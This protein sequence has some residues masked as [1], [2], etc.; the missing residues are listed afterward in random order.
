MN[1]RNW[2][3]RVGAIAE[4]CAVGSK[5][6]ARRLKK[7]I[8]VDALLAHAGTNPLVE[9]L[10]QRTF[11]NADTLGREFWVAFQQNF[12]NASPSLTLFMTGPTATTGVVEIPGLSFSTNFS[13]TPGQVTSVS[14][15]SNAFANSNDGIQNVGIR[16]S[17][18]EE[19]ALYGLNR[20]P[21]TTDAFVAYPTDILATEYLAQTYIALGSDQSASQFSVVATQDN[22]TL[23]VRPTSNTDIR[24]AGV[25]FNITLQRG[26][27]YTLASVAAGSDLTGSS[28]VSN[29]PVAVFSGNSS[30]QVPRGTS[31]VDHIVEQVPPVA[32]WGRN[33][34]TVPL[35]QRTGGDVFRVLA[36]EANTQVSL[37]GVVVATLN[38]GQFF[39]TR[40]SVA[41]TITATRPVLLSQFSTG[42]TFDNTT[43]DPF[44]AIVPPIEQLLASYTV[45]TPSTGFATHWINVFTPSQAI[46]SV[47]LNGQ[48]V[49]PAQFTAI[50]TS[51]FS[52]ARLS[53]PA[54]THTVSSSSPLGAMVYGF[55]Q[56]DSYG[57]TG[58][59]S[60]V[61][62]R[63]VASV[64]LTPPTQTLYVGQPGTVTATVLDLNGVPV[65]GARVDF[66]VS[67]ANTRSGFAFTRFNGQAEF[68]YTATNAG[69]DIVLGAVASVTGQ[70]SVNQGA[71]PNLTIANN[72]SQQ[73]GTWG[74]A[75][76]AAWRVTN[77]S[78]IT[79]TSWTD[80]IYLS[81]D[82][83][84]DGADRLVGQRPNTGSLGAGASYDASVA[85]S[86]P[87]DFNAGRYFLLVS[88]NAD[89]AQ[90][91]SNYNDNVLALSFDLL[92][93]NLVPGN[94]TLSQPLVFGQEIALAWRVNNTGSFETTRAFNDTVRLSTSPTFST[95]ATVLTTRRRTSNVSSGDGY[96]ASVSASL[97]LN[98]S[99]PSGQ[100]YFYLQTDSSGEI[101]ESDESLNVIR[102]GP[103]QV[104]LPP[105]PDLIVE[106]ISAP[107]AALSG[108]RVSVT[109]TIR[110][111]GNGAATG[112]WTDEVR[113][114]SD[115]T[116]GSD[117]FM[118]SFAFAGTIPAGG[119]ITR[120][121]LFTLPDVFSGAQRFVVTTDR[122]N[123]LFE[124]DRENN[125]AAIDD[126]VM[127]VTLRPFPNLTVSQ[128]LAPTSAFSGQQV[129][130]QWAVT[131]IGSGPTSSANW[132]DRVYLSLNTTFDASDINL[133]TQSNASYLGSGESYASSLLVTL[134]EGISGSYYFIVVADSNNQVFELNGESD[135]SRA[136]N[137]TDV[138]LTPP[139]DLRVTSVGAPTA[140][141]SGQTI[142]L[143]WTVANNGTGS[144]RAVAWTDYVY[145][146]FD[147]DQLGP[148]DRLLGS[149]RRNGELASGQNYSVSGFNVTLP[150]GVAGQAFFII[151]TDV[152]NEVFEAGFEGNNITVRGTS[153][154][155]NLTPPPDLEV[156]DVA[157]PATALAGRAITFS[158]TV[159][160]NG[161][162]ATPNSSWTD[163]YYLSAD[164]VLDGSDFALGSRSRSG[165]LDAGEEE[166]ITRTFTLP[167]NVVGSRYVLVVT[168]S[169]NQVF[170]INKV[171]NRAASAV[172][173]V[174]IDA[175]DLRVVFAG[176][177]ADNPSNV[178][179]S[180][181]SLL[182]DWSILNKGAGSTYGG[183]W[184]DRVVISADSVFGNGDDVTLLSLSNV[185]QLAQSASYDRS[186]VRV[187]LPFS[188]ASGSY[189]IF[190]QVDSGN[191]VFEGGAESNNVSAGIP[192]QLER[193]TA[194]LQVSAFVVP[195][196]L[197]T[198][199]PAV[200]SWTVVNR[201]AG[202]NVDAWFDHVYL[203]RDQN[204]GSDD[205]LLF[206]QQRTGSLAANASYSA[207]RSVNLPLDLQGQYFFI[208]HTDATNRVIETPF[209]DN[210][211]RIGSTSTGGG[212]G[213][214]P[215]DITPGPVADLIV[216]NVDAPASAFSGRSFSVTW[217]VRNNGASTTLSWIDAVYLSIDQVFDR[218]SDVYI[219][220]AERFA[221]LPAG[222]EYSQSGSFTLPQGLAGR[223][224]VFIATDNNNR[225]PERAN[226]LNNSNFDVIAMDIALTPPADLVI[227]SIDVPNNGSPGTNATITYTVR[228]DGSNP[229]VG[230]WT[231][232]LYLSADDQWD[233]GD[234]LFERV[235]VQGPLNAGT[236]YTRSVTAPLPGVLPGNYRVIIRSDIRNN[237]AESN[238]GNNLSASINSVSLDAQELTLGVA[239][240]GEL[241][242]ARAVYY[243]VVVPA[244][245]T[246]VID[247]DSLASSG[248]T[249]LFA[250]FGTMPSRTRSDFSSIQ[251]FRQDQRVVISDTEAGT[252]Y[253]LAYGTQVPGGT[254]AFR[255]TARTVEFSVFDTSYGQGG[256][257]GNRTIEVNGAKFDRSVQVELVNSEGSVIANAVDRFFE[258]STR[259]YATFNLRTVAP[260]TYSVRLSK[261]GSAPVTVASGLEVVRTL[262]V[263]EVVPYLD[264]PSAVRRGVDYSFVVNWANDTLNDVPAPLL[265]VGNTVP[266]GLTRGVYDLGVSTWFMARS[267]RPFGV[268]LP[269]DTG[270]RTFFAQSDLNAGSHNA[271]VNRVLKTED[272]LFD[273]TGISDAFADDSLPPT[274]YARAFAE[275]RR[276][277]GERAELVAA[278]IASNLS[279][280]RTEGTER[281]LVSLLQPSFQRAL[282]RVTPS[283]AGK[284]SVDSVGVDLSAREV[285]LTR[286]SD[287]LTL[288]GVTLKDGS[289]AVSQIP[290]GT[291]TVSVPGL[292]VASPLTVTHDG[293]QSILDSVVSV[294]RGHV[295]TVRLS[296]QSD[297]AQVVVRNAE[298]VVAAAPRSPEGSH[299]FAGLRE[300]VYEVEVAAIGFNSFQT[301]YVAPQDGSG[302]IL[303]TLVVATGSLSA[304]VVDENGVPIDDVLVIVQPEGF[305]SVQSPY[306]T[307]DGVLSASAVGSGS[308][309]VR[310]VKPGFEE[311]VFSGV[312][313]SPG[314]LTNLG[315]IVLQQPETPLPLIPF[316]AHEAALLDAAFIGG[317]GS[318]FEAR[319]MYA[320]YV[321][322]TGP[323]S[324]YSVSASGNEAFK[325]HPTTQANLDRIS[326]AATAAAERRLAE[327][328]PD[329]FDCDHSGVTRTYSLDE[330]ASNTRW[331]TDSDARAMLEFT[332]AT[333][334]SLGRDLWNFPARGGTFAGTV[335]GGTGQWGGPGSASALIDDTRRVTGNITVSIPRCSS[336]GTSKVRMNVT[337]TDA[338]DFVPGDT[339]LFGVP[340]FA[341]TA[342][343]ERNG[344]YWDLPFRSQ[345][346]DMKTGAASIPLS[347]DCDPCENSCATP[348]DDCEDIE[349]PAAV[350]PN[351]ILGPAGFGP[352]KWVSAFQPLAYT[353]R[354][355]NDPD[356]ATAPAQVV[357]ITSIL[358]E[359]VDAR[360]FRLGDFG[361][362]ELRVSVPEN[363]AFFTTR[364]D[365]RATRGIFVDVVA[366]VDVATR[367]I[368]WTFTSIDPATGEQPANPLLGF[369]P[370]NLTAPEGDGF[371]NFTVRPLRTAVT[372][373]RVDAEARIVFDVQAPIDTPPIF[374][375]LDA[376]R[377]VSTVE[378]LPAV[379]AS[380]FDVRWGGSDDSSG[381]G[382]ATY[383]V[384]VSE[385]GGP[386]TLWLGATTATTA[387]FAGEFGKQYRFFSTA[388]DNAGNVESAPQFADASTQTP[389]RPTVSE[390]ILNDGNAQRSRITRFVISFD[391]S[392]ELMP[393]AFELTRR[394]TALT[395]VNLEIT[396]AAGDGRT[397][398]VTFTG[399]GVSAGSLPE[400]IFDLR[401]VKEKVKG[402]FGQAMAE[403]R[404]Y[405]FHRLIGDSDG[406]RDVDTR[407]FTRFQRAFGS[408]LG[409]TNY[410]PWLD[411]D[412][413][414]DIDATDGLAIR[415][416]IGVRLKY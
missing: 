162:T 203:S 281:D 56:D 360:T 43:G 269:G 342:W 19:I 170:E 273:W 298:G 45:T 77:Q 301:Q 308:F 344:F 386:F 279:K 355:E 294:E 61:P 8:A 253:I 59:A 49:P 159:A 349:R 282:A 277:V 320:R 371:V 153:T 1:S 259:M 156:V 80:R 71:Q 200:L 62:I 241:R 405:T 121:Q 42:R 46:G 414:G 93:P 197:S 303:A 255:V 92:A 247:F 158:Y 302:S 407:D 130:V 413:D 286:Q 352:E 133:G 377:P 78:G 174:G 69:E 328:N 107:S 102:V 129:V 393:G 226:E 16:V 125:N 229:A 388:N 217:T 29:R 15:P 297:D 145:V 351:D 275:M 399:Q 395:G 151:R 287:G 276:V 73:S 199:L 215:I 394:G 139:P 262:N 17:A 318:R 333:R 112:T 27:V 10:E 356:F 181:S 208:V 299:V 398:I 110:N 114:S 358:D 36:S 295:L 330:L 335:A 363:R 2:S 91:E 206:S 312:L 149:L 334:R 285:S 347:A 33:F 4:R 340:V 196:T 354:F 325:N 54:G 400:G 373:A 366:G 83:T 249:E 70:A 211:T 106:S 183:S 178:F 76:L 237:I 28:I 21:F 72:S 214:D 367:R 143:T 122:N 266:I 317:A 323:N 192:I 141:F 209:E 338:V 64:T 126:Q 13:V 160:N 115:Q 271:F 409:Q 47:L 234:E 176:L 389:G 375:T 79:N 164:P 362:G 379:V 242:A 324:M 134:P 198:T 97:P 138:T 50:G 270:S 384:Y 111:Q 157:A 68:T 131:N 412:G 100:Y 353:I 169:G 109:W 261:A 38:R 385:D 165:V 207:T 14:V 397:F 148:T 20:V 90:F 210:N 95:S 300:G 228:N 251:P 63:D 224:Y 98:T 263:P 60:L 331:W 166:T 99:L 189:N 89:Q 293:V 173:Q 53:V 105:L 283:F 332:G 254:S 152:F 55:N 408:R 3:S 34:V 179:E 313:V 221:G 127:Q 154:Q 238:E 155:V 315:N 132:I 245:A 147:D 258:S 171:N 219:G 137:A 184:T 117:L 161:A 260:G 309:T 190:V 392:V 124:F 48:V 195:N 216:T 140:A 272:G 311:R 402:G 376:D 212:P 280:L 87:N 390:F 296:P 167:T 58:G 267:S 227:G 248:F 239:S 188:L 370:P 40:Q 185:S 31:F 35:A 186:A 361:F 291:Y 194:D 316:L 343:A 75:A 346:F 406:D 113:L 175:P 41:R 233:L 163:A 177:S 24:T 23:T 232:S 96:D 86:I 288:S 116:I 168:D 180:G 213:G 37:D 327:E 341:L 191:A 364:V 322:A 307:D 336:S 7:G 382:L 94:L 256:T 236:T 268:L 225:V 278:E 39:E 348:P 411:I 74:Q 146:S 104:D 172:L 32:T 365:L 380:A 391:Q 82:G 274:V 326:A 314:N 235:T 378:A 292:L 5:V 193:T 204:I 290:Q 30:T 381:S 101:R 201:G 319:A 120:T 18:L 404:I 252:Y 135:N 128:A 264:A 220:F 26:Q 57:Y 103:F 25:D 51:G 6:L 374:N 136:S 52:Y 182:L 250:S 350:D 81:T 65:F 401:I 88:T 345:F 142:S 218:G 84:L 118:G 339:T 310:V 369:L 357:S 383:N 329:G 230:T 415:S 305:E 12:S 257:S 403:D 85:F 246:L 44:M 223:F 243:K 187:N 150:I 372:G 222:D 416:N 289:F 66:T 368:F 119:T 11:L 202:T 265:V 123:E 304:T 306:F 205:V 240:E 321:F 9:S 387:R 67:G 22:T 144:T 231:D 244:G 359:D 410:V 337:V 284:L 108:D 396:D